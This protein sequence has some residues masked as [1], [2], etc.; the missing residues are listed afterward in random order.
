LKENPNACEVDHQA[1]IGRLV[2]EYP[3]G[4]ALSTSSAA[5]RDVL[6][7]CPPKVRV[8]SWCKPFAAWKIPKNDDGKAAMAPYA[9]EPVIF[10][11]TSKAERAERMG[12]FCRDFLLE[13][14]PMKQRVPGEKPTRFGWW[15]F[16]LLGAMPGDE[17]HDLFPG[18]GAITE[19]WDAWCGEWDT[20]G[21]LFEVSP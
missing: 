2:T 17:M 14:P 20:T 19:A 9:W 8:A 5:L 1:L 13:S 11:T 18:S 3:D 16:S 7:M 6:S 21:T 4:W 15:V 12:V 10:T